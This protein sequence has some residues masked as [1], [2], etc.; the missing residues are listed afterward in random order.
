M[1]HDLSW[2][3]DLLQGVQRDIVEVARA[4]QVPLLV[5][6]HLLEEVVS[7]SLPLLSLQEQVVSRR[8]LVVL[9]VLNVSDGLV[10]VTVWA[11]ARG[12]EAVL[13]LAQELFDHWDSVFAN[14]NAL[15]LYGLHLSVPLVSPNVGHH[16]TLRRVGV[17]NLSDQVF[18]CLGDH[19]W[20]QIVAVEDLFVEL[21]RI[22]VFKGK[23]TASHGVEDDATAPNIRVKA[24]VF[25]SSD[26][27]W[28]GI[29]RTST[30]SFE[31]LALL[32]HV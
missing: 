24:V 14:H 30:S 16:E 7:S 2:S 17:Q 3:L 9:V 26:H 25:L 20:D 13:D 8:D 31:S 27:F 11:D 19:S 32:V 15:H 23:I 5:A 1:H 28:S 10:Q 18:R 29:A 21:A 6:H 12:R 4:I 22:G